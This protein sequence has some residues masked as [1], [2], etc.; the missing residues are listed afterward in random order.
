MVS[1]VYT[2]SMGTYWVQDPPPEILTSAPR[3]L[4]SAAAALQA[5]NIVGASLLGGAVP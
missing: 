4:R 3:P 2:R 5:L 1:T